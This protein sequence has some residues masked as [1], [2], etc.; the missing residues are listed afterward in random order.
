MINN[1]SILTNDINPFEEAI[2]TFPNIVSSYAYR[3]LSQE[4]PF[5]IYEAG[6]DKIIDPQVI[7][8]VR[9]ETDIYRTFS[10][11]FGLSS[12]YYFGVDALSNE[13]S[14]IY[15]PRNL[16]VFTDKFFMSLPP[17]ETYHPDHAYFPVEDIN[18]YAEIVKKQKDYN[19]KILKYKNYK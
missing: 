14:L 3:K 8:L 6:D 18:H 7:S 4:V 5:I 17:M 15:N 2:Y 1:R 9:G 10:N 13:P 11:L 12:K 16:D 19:D